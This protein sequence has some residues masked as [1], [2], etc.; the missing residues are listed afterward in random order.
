M[1]ELV[2]LFRV[3]L[4]L[5][6]SYVTDRN[7]KEIFLRKFISGEPVNLYLNNKKKSANSIKEIICHPTGYK[8]IDKEWLIGNNP[9]KKLAKEYQ[10]YDLYST[11]RTF[12]VEE[13]RKLLELYNST[14]KNDNH[15]YHLEI[16]AEPWQGN[17][18]KAKIIILTCF[19]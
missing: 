11:T 6:C 9:W 1:K 8:K 3:E 14:K 15:K 10:G 7:G 17:P 13:D 12:A 18:L 2:E 4:L 5:R 19:C 16:P